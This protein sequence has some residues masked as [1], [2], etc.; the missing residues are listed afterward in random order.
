[1]SQIRAGHCPRRTGWRL[2]ALALSLTQNH[3]ILLFTPWTLWREDRNLYGG[4]DFVVT[5]GQNG[6]VELAPKGKAVPRVLIEYGLP[7]LCPEA[8][9]PAL[10][11]WPSALKAPLQCHDLVPGTAAPA[12]RWGWSVTLF[13]PQTVGNISEGVR[14]PLLLAELILALLE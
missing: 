11:S 2:A 4:W 10:F 9:I 8:T 7:A 3:S 13:V 6:G 14:R 12:L 1:M 5:V